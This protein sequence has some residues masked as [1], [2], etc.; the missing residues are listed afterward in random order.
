[1]SLSLSKAVDVILTD[2]GKVGKAVYYNLQ[3]GEIEA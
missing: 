2:R 3:D 1:M